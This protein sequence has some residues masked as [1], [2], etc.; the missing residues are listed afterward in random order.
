[1]HSRLLLVSSRSP[2]IDYALRVDEQRSFHERV[3]FVHFVIYRRLSLRS[4]SLPDAPS[5]TPSEASTTTSS[6]TGLDLLLDSYFTETN[7][8]SSPSYTR[9]GTHSCMLSCMTSRPS[10]NH[11]RGRS[12]TFSSYQIRHPSRP[13]VV[14]VIESHGLA[15]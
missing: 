11:F 1:M 15:S 8:V 3:T 12:P 7:D 2:R 6:V 14:D 13:S 5:T 9:I 4:I 10:Q